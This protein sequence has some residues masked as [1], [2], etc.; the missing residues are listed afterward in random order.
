M[1]AKQELVPSVSVDELGHYERVRNAFEGTAKKA[2]P[3]AEDTKQQQLDHAGGIQ[4]S[5]PKFTDFM[6]PASSSTGNAPT[7]NGHKRLPNLVK[8]TAGGASDADDDYVFRTDRLTLNNTA[9]RP[10]SGK[11]KGKGKYRDIPA[12]GGDT[13]ADG[14]DLYE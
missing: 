5:R 9:A 6:K 8:D 13:N 12:V 10:P 2:G 1:N 4:T 11:G 3:A 7:T 14:E